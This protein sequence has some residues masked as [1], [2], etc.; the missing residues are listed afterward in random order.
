MRIDDRTWAFIQAL[1][2][3]EPKLCIN[4]VEQLTFHLQEFPEGKGVAAKERIIPYLLWLRQIKDGILQ[5]AVREILAL[6]WLHESSER[7]RNPN[8]HNWWWKKKGCGCSLDIAEMRWTHSEASSP[9]LWL[10]LWW[11]YRCH[12]SFHVGAVSYALGWMWGTLSKIRMRC[13]FTKCHCW[14]S[15]NE[16]EPCIL[17]QWNLGKYS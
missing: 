2:T 15:Q 4:R 7:K 9:A 5:S 1:R 13:V 10:H 17:R 12:I 16:L 14:N 11:K 6:I 8:S 3:T